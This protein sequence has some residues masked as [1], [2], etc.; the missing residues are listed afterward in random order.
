MALVSRAAL[1]MVL[2]AWGCAPSD[3]YEVT[4]SS[5]GGTGAKDAGSGGGLGSFGGLP[6]TGGSSTGGASGG[7]GGGA[8]AA[9]VA[10]AAGAA[11]AAGSGG[12]PTCDVLYGAVTGVNQVCAE[13]SGNC[14]LAA[15]TDAVD[16]DPG[17]PCGQIC[18]AAGGECIQVL[19]NGVDYCTP[20]ATLV[21][22]CDTADQS[23]LV[24]YCSR[25]CGTNPPCAPGK[26]C[27]SGQCV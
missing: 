16:G 3:D 18:T 22:T 2:V 24:C 11:G 12:I 4:S 26:T 10:G 6:A 15:D 5:G 9:G 23:N 8:G 25:G 27:T 13:E 14:V 20:N 7:L 17:Q 19:D 1:V 21:L